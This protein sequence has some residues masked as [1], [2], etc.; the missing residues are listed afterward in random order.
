MKEF[1]IVTFPDDRLVSVD[2]IPMKRTNKKFTVETGHHSFDLA[3]PF[4][5]TPLSQTLLV[6]LTSADA[7][8]VIEF[9]QVVTPRA[10]RK[11]VRKV[12]VR[13]AAKKSAKK[14]ARKS[15]KKTLK[16]AVK[17][18]VR[19]AVKKATKKSARKPTRKSAT[20]SARRSAKRPARKA[21]RKRTAKRVARKSRR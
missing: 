13:K 16:K 10:G 11:R 1:V 5:Y 20:S 6:E 18:A 17:K 7:P 9:E 8:M 21:A 14:S 2:R 4:D 15:A 3:L 12:G 19:K